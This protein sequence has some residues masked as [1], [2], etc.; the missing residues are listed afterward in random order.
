M[1]PLYPE[2]DQVPEAV[3]CCVHTALL[4]IDI[5]FNCFSSYVENAS[6]VDQTPCCPGGTDSPGH[7]HLDA[8]RVLT[9]HGMHMANTDNIKAM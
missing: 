3:Q 1:L 7:T 9:V 8:P 2:S 4:V 5:I 6:T